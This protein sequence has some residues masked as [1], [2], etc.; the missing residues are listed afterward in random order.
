VTV[1]VLLCNFFKKQPI[2]LCLKKTANLSTTVRTHAR[3]ARTHELTR[4]TDCLLHNNDSIVSTQQHMRITSTTQIIDGPI[5]KRE[6]K[7]KER[8]RQS[9]VSGKPDHA[10]LYCG[11]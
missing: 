6:I 4:L 7:R 1:Y 3:T 11:L 10:Q 5:L 2:N 9:K 8:K